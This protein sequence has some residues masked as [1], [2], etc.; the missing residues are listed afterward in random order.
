MATKKNNYSTA[1]IKDYTDKEHARL[2]PNLIFGGETGD[3][4]NPYSSMKLT[5]IREISDNAVGEIIQGFANKIKVTYHKDGAVTVLDNG[6]GLPVDIG[7]TKDGKKV[8]GLYKTMA[9]TKSGSNLGAETASKST[10][11]NGVGAS[12]SIFLSEYAIVKSYRDNKIYELHFYD[13]D[14]GFFEDSSK[15]SKETFTPIGKD[16]TKMVISKDNRPASEKKEFK[17]GTSVTIKLDNRWFPVKYPFSK[18]DMR[19]RLRG[20]ALQLKD[21]TI[22]IID[23]E[24]NEE[25]TFT[26]AN[27][28]SDLLEL[29]QAQE[30]ICKP[31]SLKGSI[32]YPYASVA[33]TADKPLDYELVFSWTP[34][35]DY[36]IE[37]YVNTIRTRLGGSHEN[38][39]GKALVNSFNEKFR[40]MRG[41]LTKSDVDPIWEDYQEGLSIILTVSVPEPPFIGQEKAELSDK[42]LQKYLMEDIQTQ[43]D[44]YVN[45]NKNYDNVKAIGDKV[46]TASKNRAKARE[47][48]DLKRQASSL[49]KSTSLP[50]SLVD[51]RITHDP[52]SEL[53]I[54]EGDSAL[55]SVK[56][57]RDATYQ[58]CM[59]I[60]GKI[61]NTRKSTRKKVLDNREVQDIIRALE[62]E[63]GDNNKVEGSRYCQVSIAS[64][65]DPD[66]QAIASLVTL[67]FYD[68]FPDFIRQGRLFKIE[69][70]LHVI[71]IGKETFYAMDDMEKEKILKKHGH[72]GKV[73]VSRSKGL[74]E[75]PEDIMARFGLDR[76][77]RV[78]TRV[79]VKDVEEA[80][81]MLNITLGEDTDLRK[82]W[83][84]NNPIEYVSE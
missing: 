7:T 37:S 51:C 42:Q 41:M 69:T 71:K 31:I 23:E 15:P 55:T 59:P 83:I 79:T 18:E 84:E 75:L 3:A 27:G 14:P 34:D 52:L 53:I 4:E 22:Q 36:Y 68:L 11:L 63:I 66:G 74:G 33:G 61:I 38:A 67:L 13:G 56:S 76:E 50:T 8:S 57:A 82:E 10:S 9:M 16:L 21:A 60:R 46:V 19:E 40:S 45:A 1:D 49:T 43:L 25:E 62:C 30:P 24:L 32:T 2:R 64:D 29:S 54:T 5:A 70:P 58:A 44:E 47:L 81:K 35:F 77:T 80:E 39:V 48:R 73:Q 28:I 17:V 20:T 72:K 78:L 6:R 26:Y 12:S 65:S